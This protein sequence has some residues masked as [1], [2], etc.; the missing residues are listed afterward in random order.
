MFNLEKRSACRSSLL[1]VGEALLVLSTFF[2]RL[3]EEEGEG[4][5]I[6]MRT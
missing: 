6:H 5:A 4:E 3:L 1:W 2:L